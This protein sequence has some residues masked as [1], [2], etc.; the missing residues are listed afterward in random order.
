MPVPVGYEFWEETK[1][2]REN[3][4]ECD[5]KDPGSVVTAFIAAMNA[6]ETAARRQRR[7]NRRRSDPSAYQGPVLAEMNRIFATYR[8]VKDRKH[9]RKGSFQRLP[10]YDPAQESIADI[11]I[12]HDRRRAR[13]ITKRQAVP[14]SGMCRYTLYQK[15]GKWFIDHL[16]FEVDGKWRS[17]VLS[18]DRLPTDCDGL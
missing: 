10:E 7:A 14:G 6:R 16:E 18:T 13:V 8:T 17:H 2:V 9:G 4:T 15:H 5:F 1:T 11:T 12:D 3:P